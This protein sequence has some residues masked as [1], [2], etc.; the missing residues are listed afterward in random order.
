MA[1]SRR[2]GSGLGLQGACALAVRLLWLCLLPLR[3]QT[4]LSNGNNQNLAE[5]CGRSKVTGKIFGGQAAGP[6]R[7][8][9]QASLVYNGRHMCGA[10]LIASNW[11]ISAAHCFQRSQ[12]PMD[13]RILLGYNQLSKPSRFSRQ[14][15]IDKV[16]IHEDYNRKYCF[17]SDITLLQ[18]VLPVDFNS[19]IRPACLPDN[20]TMLPMDSSCW[21]T[22]WGMFT[23]DVLVPTTSH[24][25]EANVSL[26][27][28]DKCKRFYIP[29]PGTPLD[30][31][32][33]VHEDMI[34][35]GG[36]WDDKTIC[37]GDTGG[38]LVCFLNDAWHLIGVTS[39]GWHCR[40]PVGYSVSVRVTYF[41][42]WIKDKQRVTPIPN[43]SAALPEE[44]PP[45][46]TNVYIPEEGAVCRP[47]VFLVLLSPA[48]LLL[49]LLLQSL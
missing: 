24:L 29:P 10:T 48:T 1:G 3:T 25:Q 43:P 34:C 30:Q 42:N 38:P 17:G 13:Y 7:W 27:D 4:K 9:W 45:A 47:R 37:P 5:A 33:T 23:E 31:V 41:S 36:F 11:V 46:M 32:V 22:G 20:E 26:A 14:I 49:L 44:K 40:R 2:E 19:H 16:I 15:R 28:Q 12:N 21:I 6:E 35:S 8:P 18:L 39:W